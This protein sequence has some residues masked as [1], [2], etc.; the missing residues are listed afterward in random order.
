VAAESSAYPN[1]VQ[2]PPRPLTETI[3]RGQRT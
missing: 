2:P 3:I 1:K